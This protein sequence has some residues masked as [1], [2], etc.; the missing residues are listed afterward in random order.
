MGWTVEKPWFDSRQGQEI[1]P[2]SILL[3]SE[4]HPASHP[5]ANGCSF[6]D[7]TALGTRK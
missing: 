1:F 3:G 6:P 4:A 2:Q 7:G 5:L